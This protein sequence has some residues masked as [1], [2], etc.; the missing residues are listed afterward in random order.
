MGMIGRQPKFNGAKEITRS[1]SFDT[2]QNHN[3]AIRGHNEL[4]MSASQGGDASGGE[5]GTIDESL[6]LSEMK[7]VNKLAIPDS[8]VRCPVPHN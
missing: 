3:V 5:L 2:I 4:T 6:M 8:L 1:I 7:P